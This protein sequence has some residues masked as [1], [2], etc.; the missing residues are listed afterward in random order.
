MKDNEK[1]SKNLNWYLAQPIETQ[2]ELFKHY[3][4]IAKLIANQVFEEEVAEK[5]G[6]RYERETQRYNR[7][8]SNPGSIRIGEERVKMFIPRL[9]DKSTGKTE[10]LENY[11]KLRATELPSELLLKKI[12]YGLSE[13]NYGEVAKMTAESFGLSQSS[14]SRAFV[15]ESEKVLKEFES[16]DLS[17]YDF[18]GLVI[19]GKYLQKEQVV[20]ALG[21]T[22]SGDKLPLGFIHSTTENSE[23]IGELLKDLIRRDFKFTDGLLVIT[24]GS[25]GLI[26]GIKKTFGKY[27]ISQRCTWHKRENVVSYLP[28]EIQDHYRGKLQRAYLEPEYATAK[29]MLNEILDEL[30]EINRSAA[31]SLTE[32]LAETLTLHRLGLVEQLGKSLLTTNVIES[33]NSQLGNYLRK[34]RHWSSSNMRARWIA[35]SLIQI[36]KRMRKINNYK[37][38]NLLRTAIKSE[39]KLKQNKV[40]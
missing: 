7:W 40:A 20:I 32:G 34:V 18:V 37:K 5:A 15:E 16:R 24:D 21:I 25:T 12:L 31:K 17:S 35:T 23:S 2:L 29:I 3:T 9:Y 33:L 14:I 19:D 11:K 8:G 1:T 6:K 28:K 13:N 26:K 39:L 30:K 36:E 10:S 22:I 27:A 38:L 4:E